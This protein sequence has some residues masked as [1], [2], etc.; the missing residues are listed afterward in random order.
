MS[1]LLKSI[2]LT[3]IEMHKERQYRIEGWCLFTDGMEFTLE[4]RGDNSAV[5]SSKRLTRKREDLK[6]VLKGIKIPE[7]AGFAFYL[8][9]IPDIVEKFKTIGIYVISA[10]G[11]EEIFSKKTE[12]LQKEYEFAKIFFNVD[13]LELVGKQIVIRGWVIDLDEKESIK[14]EDERGISLPHRM[15]R[16]VRPDVNKN[17]K[18]ANQDYKCAFNISIMRKEIQGQELRI[19][20]SNGT[21]EKSYVINMKEFDFE[22]SRKGRLKKALA[23]ENKENNKAYISKYG[24]KAF[25]HYLETQMNPHYGDYNLWLKQHSATVPMLR[26]QKNQHFKYEPLIS[27]VI[28][29]YNTP[30]KYLKEIIDSVLQQSYSKVQLCLADGSTDRGVEK[31]V[32]RKYGKNPHVVYKKLENNGGISENTNAA[33]ALAAGDF[34]MLADHDDIVAKDAVYEIVK[35]INQNPETDIVYT[36]EDKVTMDGKDF[37]EPCFKP[38]FNLDFLRSSNYICH[39][40]VVRR[41]L[42]HEIGGFRKEFDGAQDF[43]LIL[44]CCEKARVIAH[45]PK[46]LYHWRSHPNSTAGNPDSKMYAFEAGRK[47]LEEHYRRVGIKAS[48]ELTKIFGRYRT[49][50]EIEGEPRISIIIPN[51][52]HIDDLDKCLK[53]VYEKSSYENFEIIIAENNS[54]EKE[55]FAYYEMLANTHEN[56]R[57]ITWKGVFNYAAIN[58]YAVQYASGDYYLFLNNDVEI[59]SQHWMEEMLGYCQREDVGITGAKLYYP[60]ET[61]QHAGVV[62]GLGGIAGHVFS[63]IP[64]EEYGYGA[65]LVSAQDLSAVTAA[66][67]MTDKR[68]FEA[69]DGFDESFEVAF[70]DVDYCMKVRALDK[71]VVFTPY[72]ELYHYE[73]KSRGKEETA[74]QLERFRGEVERFRRKWPDILKNGDPYYNKNL[75]LKKGDCSLRK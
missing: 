41:I 51:K 23:K 35:A 30:L 7:D 36:D 49:F 44:R 54:V 26:R 74:A 75:T 58:N 15:E 45:V 1:E 12:E 56:L 66:C 40:F 6:E 25:Y 69:V 71:L 59:I 46:I 55:T 72:A 42:I 47:A 34:I 33:L 28:P 65:R 13:Y 32:L 9:D 53:S 63:C 17:Y 31:F 21:A 38:D 52:D 73:S 10:D 70:N 27:V 14:V 24:W 20:F 19:I 16:L 5:L 67:M 64:R 8:F 61:V 4:V 22:H 39:I 29:L 57:V 68:I 18:L 2:D 37:F 11:E 43:D 60:D 3:Q 50:F 62:I 48:V